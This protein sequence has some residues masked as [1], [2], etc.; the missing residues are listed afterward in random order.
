MLVVMQQGA[1]DEQIQRVIDRLVSL[2]FTVHRST[3]VMHTVLG[4]VGPVEDM[5]P[6]DFE[7]MD[8]VKECHRIVSPYKLVSR[9]FRPQGTV[10]KIGD[11]EIGGDHVVTMAGPCSV[12][13]REQI[14]CIAAIVAAQG[15]KVLRGGAFKPRSS[16]YSF[17]GLG[18]EGLKL[19]RAAADRHGLLVVSEIMDHTQL[20]MLLT[21]A[22]IL[23]IGARNMQNFNL[24]REVGRVRK[25]V[26][27]KRGISATIEELLLAAEYIMSGGNY[28][29]I[30]CERGIRTFETYTRNTMDVS[31]IPVV[32]KL[33]HLPIVG[34][35][36]HGTG[37]RD[38]IFPMARAAVAAGADGLLVEVHPD[39]DHAASDG[40]QTLNPAQYAEMMQQVRSIASAVG[41]SA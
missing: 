40:A 36:S 25:P 7:V 21:Y 20:P 38:L 5:D 14:E 29:V 12:E 1:T 27:L 33:S 22:D 34:D 23:Q 41:R 2:G 37:R 8:G 31:A 4:G 32:K 3:G 26:L 9:H 18:E 11:V 17:Q 39:P 16:P 30:L 6:A 19:M 28:D 35:P 13:S 24:L 10:I 15:A